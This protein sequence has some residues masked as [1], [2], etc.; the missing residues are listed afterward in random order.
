MDGSRAGEEA[1]SRHDEDAI[2]S[3]KRWAPAGLP[4]SQPNCVSERSSQS[5]R[6]NPLFAALFRNASMGSA[7]LDFLPPMRQ[8]SSA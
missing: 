3:G 5:A 4:F 8:G 2:V 1:V 6:K 7:A